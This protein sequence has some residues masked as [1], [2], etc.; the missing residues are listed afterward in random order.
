MAKLNSAD[1]YGSAGCRAPT[2]ELK[3]IWN[4]GIEKFLTMVDA[5]SMRLIY[6]TWL[7]A[8]STTLSDKLIISWA[9]HLLVAASSRRTA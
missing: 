3:E 8:T 4:I 2:L 1:G 7:V 9:K 6:M 5:R